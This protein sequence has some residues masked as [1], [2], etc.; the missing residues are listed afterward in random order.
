MLSFIFCLS[1][2]VKIKI[3]W[4]GYATVCLEVQDKAVAVSTN[5]PCQELIVGPQI[6]KFDT[7]TQA[8]LKFDTILKSTCDMTLR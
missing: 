8:I 3:V 4:T 5:E 7:V 6:P 1:Y 2:L